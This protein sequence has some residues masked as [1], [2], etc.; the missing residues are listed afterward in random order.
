MAKSARALR[1]TTR[2]GGKINIDINIGITVGA[3]FYES[4]A[5]SFLC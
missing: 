1:G 2:D 3:C 5:F 4:A